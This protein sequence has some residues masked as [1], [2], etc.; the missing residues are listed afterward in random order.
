MG[1]GRGMAGRGE[2]IPGRDGSL[3]NAPTKARGMPACSE[4]R[5]PWSLAE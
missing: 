3:A 4:K 2:G 1:W 5:V